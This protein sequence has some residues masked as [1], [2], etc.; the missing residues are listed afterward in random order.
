MTEF[1]KVYQQAL[2]LKTEN[3]CRIRNGKCAAARL[4]LKKAV[5]NICARECDHFDG[6][7][8]I[9]NIGC[10]AWICPHM[11]QFSLY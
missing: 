3:I 8:T 6:D 7:C 2:D 1:D 5:C 4:G 9:K 10:K 11:E